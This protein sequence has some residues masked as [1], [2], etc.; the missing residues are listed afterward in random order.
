MAEGRI[1]KALSG[2]YYV[3]AEDGIYARKGRGVFRKQKITPLVGEFVKFDYTDKNESYIQTIAD[4]KNELTKTPR[5]NI[6]KAVIV[7]TVRE[8]S[9]STLFLNRFL[10]N[11]EAK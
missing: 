11:L 7:T 3:Q 10:V 9:F 1:V 6:N 4:R 8:Q 2:F 5:A